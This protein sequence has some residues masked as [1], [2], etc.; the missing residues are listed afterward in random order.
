MI[1][2]I[3]SGDFVKI[4]VAKNPWE[5]LEK[6][7]TG[8]PLPMEMIAIAPGGYRHEKDYHQLLSEHHYSR[9]WYRYEGRVIQVI[10]LIH[11]GHPE[12]QK[13]PVFSIYGSD[14]ALSDK[15][16]PASK[17]DISAADAVR[18]IVNTAVLMR[19]NEP[20]IDVRSVTESSRGPGILIWIPGYIDNGETIVTAPAA[21]VGGLTNV[22]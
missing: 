9:E 15:R 13:R 16:R 1:Y 18:L 6:F 19:A 5:R 8:N 2:F 11:E 20:M 4:G 14:H 12:L 3:R 17:G 22:D 7:R 21:V 10:E